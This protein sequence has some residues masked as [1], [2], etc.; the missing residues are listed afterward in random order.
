MFTKLS[1]CTISGCIRA[2]VYYSLVGVFVIGFC[3][4]IG[5]VV[6]WAVK[7]QPAM[8][9]ALD[10]LDDLESALNPDISRSPLDNIFTNAEADEFSVAAVLEVYRDTFLGSKTT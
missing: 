9:D 8:D 10:P 6:Y 3:F 1:F 2:M 5:G 4:G 7:D